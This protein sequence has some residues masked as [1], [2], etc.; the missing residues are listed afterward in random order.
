LSRF[1]RATVGA[2]ITYRENAY[3]RYG[4]TPTEEQA[5]ELVQLCRQ[6]R[7]YQLDKCRKASGVA[8]D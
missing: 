8:H 5:K 2:I 1:T 4:N 3:E 7:L 6:A